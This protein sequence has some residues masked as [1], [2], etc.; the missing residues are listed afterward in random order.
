[1]RYRIVDTGGT[2][3]GIVAVDQSMSLEEN[4]PATFFAGRPWL[5]LGAY[6]ASSG[7][8]FVIAEDDGSDSSIIL[9][10]ARVTL[11]ES[12]V[13]KWQELSLK[14][15]PI[16]AYSRDV[17][18]P[19]LSVDLPS[20]EI[21]VTPNDVSPRLVPVDSLTIRNESLEFADQIAVLPPEIL[22]GR[23]LIPD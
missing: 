20:L 11:S 3:L 12:P 18:I 21:S 22:D 7:S 17:L 19:R 10:A 6:Q 2:L 5:N 13:T 23:D 8:I 14:N 4:G 1:M 15:N 16:D 9:D